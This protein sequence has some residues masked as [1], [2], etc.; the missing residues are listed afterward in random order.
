MIKGNYNILYIKWQSEFVAVGCLTSDDFN[1][2]VEMIDVNR[3]ST[4]WKTRVPTNQSYN[5]SFD[6]LVKNTNF[7]GGDSSKISLDRLRV[8]KR[9]N[10]LIE[11]QMQTPNNNLLLV[12]K[13]F[14]YIT[15]LSKNSNID[16]FITFNATI[17]GFGIPLNFYSRLINLQNKLQHTL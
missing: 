17:E 1:E 6:G 12:D 2:E 4:A 15:S 7:I 9:S 10:T 16:E 3:D 11:W 13:G 14:G 8:L 5:F